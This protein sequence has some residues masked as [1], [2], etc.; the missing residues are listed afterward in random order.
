M[1]KNKLWLSTEETISTVGIGRTR[2]KELKLN[3]ELKAGIHWVYLSGC[4]NS[5]LGWDVEALRK[6]QRSKTQELT[7]A[8]TKAAN[9]ISDFSP[10]VE[11]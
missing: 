8:P 4:K 6:W 10:M 7:E 5:K 11:V 9:E 3:G 2:L 1:E